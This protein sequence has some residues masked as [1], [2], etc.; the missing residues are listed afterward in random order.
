MLRM[1]EI[2]LYNY[3]NRKCDWCPNKLLSERQLIAHNIS[4]DVILNLIT[5]LKRM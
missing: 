4:Q 5:D 2:E 3:C 1:V